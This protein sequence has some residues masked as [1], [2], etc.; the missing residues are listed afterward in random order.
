MR[1]MQM[2]TMSWMMVR[3][4]I[5]EP[6]VLS[7]DENI[8]SFQGFVNLIMVSESDMSPSQGN[9]ATK[10]KDFSIWHMCDTIVLYRVI[11]SAA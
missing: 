7:L 9:D 3:S 1:T 11:T 2:N 6:L 10:W 8:N 5:Y 4:M